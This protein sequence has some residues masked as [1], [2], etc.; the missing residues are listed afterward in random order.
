M[1]ADDVDRTDLGDGTLGHGEVDRDPVALERR[2]RGFNLCTISA[3]GEVLAFEF[4]LS[5]NFV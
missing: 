5:Y 1:G 4:L 3:L 2:D